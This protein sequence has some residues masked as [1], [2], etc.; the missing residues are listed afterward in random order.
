M[1]TAKCKKAF[2]KFV[3]IINYFCI[4]RTTKS[5]TE[6]SKCPSSSTCF[7]ESFA[8][9]DFQAIE[10]EMPMQFVKDIKEGC[11]VVQCLDK[12]KSPPPLPKRNSNISLITDH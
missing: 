12:P 8:S 5:R 4:Y 9:I 11:N 6:L 1:M 10:Y 2:I 3:N 7:E